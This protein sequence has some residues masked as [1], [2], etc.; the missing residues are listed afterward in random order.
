[1]TTLWSLLAAVFAIWAWLKATELLAANRVAAKRR[2]AEITLRFIC[3]DDDG[4]TKCDPVVLPYKPRRDQ[5]SRAE[6]A[7]IISFYY[8]EPRFDPSILRRVMEDGS[9]NRVL[10]GELDDSDADETLEIPCSEEFLNRIRQKIE[11]RDEN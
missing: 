7:G 11:V 4:K 5:L 1:M 6:L 10:A 2:K 9:L 3:L 8:G